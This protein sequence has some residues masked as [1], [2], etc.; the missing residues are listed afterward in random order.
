MNFGNWD[1]V[2]N[3]LSSRN[4]N[5]NDS[6][7]ISRINDYKKNTCNSID[8]RSN[9]EFESSPESQNFKLHVTDNLLTDDS[10][11]VD[12][13]VKYNKA[14]NHSSSDIIVIS[15]SSDEDS[16]P[17]AFI[18]KR[19]DNINKIST[20]YRVSKSKNQNYTDSDSPHDITSEN[21]N[22]LTGSMKNDNL[23]N[24]YNAQKNKNTSDDSYEEKTQDT[25][26]HI[27]DNNKLNSS[28]I[29]T[30][31]LAKTNHKLNNNYDN[32][33]YNDTP[34]SMKL[35]ECT[36]PMSKKDI[37]NIKKKID[38]RRVVLF[39]SPTTHWSKK[40]IIDE[41]DSE[42]ND[43]EDDENSY[44]K[45][46]IN[47]PVLIE[48]TISD[49]ESIDDHQCIKSNT[50]VTPP[51]ERTYSRNP[52]I[53]LSESKKNQI[54][55]W[56]MYN[57]NES[58]SDDSLSQVPP[59][60]STPPGSG[61]SSLERL[62]INYETPNNRDKFRRN[63]NCENKNSDKT[64]TTTTNKPKPKNFTNDNFLK[65]KKST[66]N[67]KKNY[68]P[69]TISKPKKVLSKSPDRRQTDINN[70]DDI[71]EKLYG[72]NWRDKIIQKSPDKKKTNVTLRSRGVQT[73]I[74]K[75]TI[76]RVKKIST[77][78]SS[79]NDNYN[80]PR[81]KNKF[82]NVEKKLETVIRKPRKDSFIDD[83]S[84]CS[85]GGGDTTYMTALTNP[86]V[87]LDNNLNNKNN[88]PMTAR[89][90]IEIC[91]TDD[92]QDDLQI[93][94]TN[95]NNKKLSFS[96]DDDSSSGT[97]EYDPY[98]IVLPKNTKKLNSKKI[99]SGKINP[100]WPSSTFDR[101]LLKTKSFLE[102]LSSSVPMDISHQDAKKYK[103]NFKNTKEELCKVLYKLYNEKIFDNRLPS[104]MSI[105]WNIRMR[106]TAGFCYNKKSTKTI[107]GI[108]RSSRIVLASKILDSADRLRDTLVHEMCHAAAW[109]LN[110]VCD[111]HGSFWKAW[112]S[113]AMK[114][115]P[116][117]PP[118][119]RCHDYK[120]STKFTY[121]CTSCGYSIG[122][123]SK[124]LD[125]EKKRCGHC[126]GKFELLINRVTKSGTTLQTP[127]TTKGPTGFA[128]FVK[129]NYGT[130]KKERQGVAHKEV[131]QILGNRKADML[132]YVYM[133]RTCI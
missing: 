50:H 9:S 20:K 19:H 15:D 113:K 91:D 7:K 128:L 109:L 85:G 37:V 125:V 48:E 87:S 22:V 89:R 3:S 114:A 70:Y 43:D 73:D 35:S 92:E 106:G 78:S 119:R 25:R 54:S 53:V 120:I 1:S 21:E 123:H 101:D 4:K 34:K 108:T 42:T 45:N 65:N 74:K 55:N 52:S 75:K 12:V 40:T 107:G 96:G 86:S 5:Y 94:N 69:I 129:E 95:L 82:F 103:I 56:L 131:M 88:T 80:T 2:E 58:K 51:L 126:F 18:Q 32:K 97:S 111:G 93:K 132:R 59:S 100:K 67:E 57:P 76:Q 60:L 118:I 64:S 41:T 46:K 38:S 83:S 124:S 8:D 99:Q 81:S 112:A 33:K 121:R 49:Q 72:S 29:L 17:S 117:L 105:E 27:P 10:P 44:L 98:D 110:E 68:T 71:L 66:S 63:I 77:S 62:E 30:S 23:E 31:D 102:S 130:V 28:I 79:S 16:S 6:K 84:V 36:T 61:N 104:D 14:N 26:Y 11:E 116:D 90:V 13:I 39:N 122:R 127:K 24:L 47:K 115:F 133:R